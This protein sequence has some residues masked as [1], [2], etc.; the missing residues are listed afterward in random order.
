MLAADKTKIYAFDP[1]IEGKTTISSKVIVKGLKHISGIAIDDHHH[2]IFVADQVG[3]DASKVFGYPY[4]VNR[5]V[6][7][8]PQL[9]VDF[10]NARKVYAGPKITALAV[11]QKDHVLYMADSKDAEIIALQYHWKN[12]TKES[13]PQV[14]HS[15]QAELSNKITGLAVDGHDHI[16]WS[17]GNKGQ[18]K[19]ALVKDHIKD[20]SKNTT[21]VLDKNAMAVRSIFLDNKNEKIFYIADATNLVEFDTDHGKSNLISDDFEDA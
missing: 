4:Y 5:S 19:G 3:T 15:K 13:K 18:S 1:A 8:D 11:D 2:V 6:E 17:N 14:T 20:H 7:N 9:H 10:K 16:Y 12:S 21:H